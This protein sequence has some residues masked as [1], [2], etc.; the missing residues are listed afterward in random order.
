[1]LGCRN[2]QQRLAAEITI[3]QVMLPTICGCEMGITNCISIITRRR[4]TPVDTN[5]LRKYL[6]FD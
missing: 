1:M 3:L 5:F 6:T 2:F 4:I